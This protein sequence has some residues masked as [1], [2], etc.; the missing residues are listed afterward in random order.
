MERVRAPLRLL[1]R[2]HRW[3]LASILVLALVVRIAVIV[4]TPTYEPSYDSGDYDRHATA[5][6]TG[7]GYPES[8]FA[9]AGGPTAFRPPVYPYMLGALYAVVGEHG[10]LAGR[11]LGALFGVLVVGLLYLVGAEL[12]GRREGLIA[13][14]LAA[15]WPPLFLLG[16]ALVTEPI[17]L[18]LVLAAVLLVLR[19][20]RQ[21]SL[22]AVGAAGVCCGLAALTRSNGLL[23]LLAI[24]VGL[25]FASGLRPRRSQLVAT[26][27]LAI[28]AFLTL[29]PWAIRNAQTFDRF[30]PIT[31]QTGFALAGT[32]NP[33]AE[34]FP[35]YR[36]TWILPQAT[37]R[38]A[39]LYERRDLD[40][41]ALDEVLLE[42]ALAYALARPAYAL[43]ATALNGL[44]TFEL[45][46]QD[47][48]SALAN[49]RQLGLSPRAAALE[50]LSFYLLAVLAVIGLALM[51]RRPREQRVPWFVWLVP[52]LLVA[53]ALPIL[54]SP[55]YR[56]PLYPF[57]VLA[58][59]GGVAALLRRAEGPEH[60]H[61]RLPA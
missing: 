55:R 54:G 35:G 42:D 20:Q 6:A 30:V 37:A 14:A 47:P 3:V 32:Y 31:S 52:V 22:W 53:A 41:V 60:R 8:V 49:A 25:L 11:V 58:A 13:A 36:A 27:T 18:A 24:G 59:T 39:P 57:V 56:A 4:A 46:P 40:E 10:V 5:I 26:A 38:Y 34:N 21:K 1:D 2:H 51:R 19:H 23:L 12:L 17:F 44:R 33:E 7:K 43:E 61:T 48:A 28:A 29:A 15:F 9:A 16:T 50:R 45:L